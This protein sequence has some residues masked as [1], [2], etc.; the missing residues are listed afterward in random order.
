VI[1]ATVNQ[2]KAASRDVF[3]ISFGIHNGWE[4]EAFKR[5]INQGIDSHLEAVQFTQDT[6]NRGCPR[7]NISGDTLH[8][9]VR[10]L[11]EVEYC[12]NDEEC[13]E[14]EIC[15]LAEASEMLASCICEVLRL[16]AVD[17]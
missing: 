13:T 3:P 1:E 15:S 14:C 8:V 12:G 7:F 6:D 17:A 5:A 2:V 16:E 9:L 11:L 4:F 10:R